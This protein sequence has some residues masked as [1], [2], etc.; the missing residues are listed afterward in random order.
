MVFFFTFI[1]GKK[2]AAIFD[3]NVDFF[4]KHLLC[5]NLGASNR[6]PVHKTDASRLDNKCRKEERGVC[7]RDKRRS[8][9][10]LSPPSF[11]LVIIGYNKS[12]VL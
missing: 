7:E 1:F 11:L 5:Q 6:T 9:F 2:G 4:L 10:I 12:I 8:R 3:S